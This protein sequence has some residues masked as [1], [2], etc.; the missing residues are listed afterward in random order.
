MKMTVPLTRI[1]I[2]L[3]LAIQPSVELPLQAIE[4][5]VAAIAV[6][7][8]GGQARLSAAQLAALPRD[9]VSARFHDGPAQ[10]FTGPSV[11]AVLRRAGARVDTIRGPALARYLVVEASDGYRVVLSLA[12]LA[13][14]LGN[15]SALLVDRVD[16]KPVPAAEGPWRLVVPEDVHPSRWV[17]Q[18]VALRL[19]TAA[20]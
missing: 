12:E 7:Y 20:R 4:A 19:L 9:S 14:T 10:W 18:V 1:P 17:R 8:P 3:L 11:L 5:P 2:V 6:T 15:R 16:G 13:P